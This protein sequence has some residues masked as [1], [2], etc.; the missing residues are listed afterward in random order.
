MPV[1]KSKLYLETSI[2]NFLF[3]ED[4]PDKRKS[5]EL[6]FQRISND[7]HELY[8]SD[9]VIAEIEAASK[10]KKKQL[11][12]AIEHYR[13]VQL[14][15]DKQ[16]VELAD[17]YLEAGVLSV[18]HYNDLLHLAFATTHDLNLLLSWNL[19]HLVKHKTRI[20]VSSI[21][22]FRTSKALR[23]CVDKHS[24]SHQERRRNL[25]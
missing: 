7:K 25:L 9:T 10:S 3:V 15:S 24:L 6:L 16:V 11:L 20:M 4:A 8:I 22:K 1:I 18:T 17:I 13:P 5:T 19:K 12:S 2:W 21:L 14:A 23:K